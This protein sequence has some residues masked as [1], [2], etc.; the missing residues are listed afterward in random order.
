MRAYDSKSSLNETDGK[1]E[2]WI[3]QYILWWMQEI[4]EELE[5]W[6]AKRV[7]NEVDVL[8]QEE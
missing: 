8:V 1:W 6:H 5:K 4:D 2:I 7:Y 3:R